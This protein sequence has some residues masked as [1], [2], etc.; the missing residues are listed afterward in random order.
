MTSLQSL[1]SEAP[2]GNGTCLRPE[3]PEPSPNE[4]FLVQHLHK[5]HTYIG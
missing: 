2:A 4:V 5:D 3:F 1:H